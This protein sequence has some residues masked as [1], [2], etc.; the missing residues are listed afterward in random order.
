VAVTCCD[1]G[2]LYFRGARP[3]PTEVTLDWIDFI[4]IADRLTRAR[5]VLHG[6]GE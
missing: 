6:E 1:L 5:T 4:R 2:D 3:V